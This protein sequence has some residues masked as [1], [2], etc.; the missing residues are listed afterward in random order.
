MLKRRF[1]ELMEIQNDS[2][3]EKSITGPTEESPKRRGFLRFPKSWKEVK[4]LGWK[5]IL[6]FILFYLIRDS[7]LYILIPYLIAKGL[8]F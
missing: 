4:Q 6:A 5:F 8:F 3:I 1:E 7:I 2:A